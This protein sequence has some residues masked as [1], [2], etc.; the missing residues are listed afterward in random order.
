MSGS[1]NSVAC[2]ELPEFVRNILRNM[3]LNYLLFFGIDLLSQ[4]SFDNEVFCD[5][6]L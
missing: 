6:H 4:V 1:G 3:A 2:E 5:Y